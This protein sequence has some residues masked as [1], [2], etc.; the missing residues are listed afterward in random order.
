[1]VKFAKPVSF[2]IVDIPGMFAIELLEYSLLY[3]FGH[4]DTL[5]PYL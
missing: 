4:P 1:M 3:L 2:Y 5:I